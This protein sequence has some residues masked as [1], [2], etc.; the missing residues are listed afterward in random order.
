MHNFT[1]FMD[2]L[3]TDAQFYFIHGCTMHNI[4]LFMSAP[5]HSLGYKFNSS[6]DAVWIKSGHTKFTADDH[7]NNHVDAE[8]VNADSSMNTIQIHFHQFYW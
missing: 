5:M 4:T 7:Y 2:A 1:L 8:S 3:N 6:A